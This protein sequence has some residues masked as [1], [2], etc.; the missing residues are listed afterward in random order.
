LRQRGFGVS[1]KLKVALLPL[2]SALL[3][4]IY[5]GMDKYYLSEV[6]SDPYAYSFLSMWLGLICTAIVLVVMRIPAKKSHLLGAYIDPNFRGFII[7]RGK[8][9]LWLIIAGV[10]AALQTITY[11]YLVGTSSPS[12]LLPFMQMVIVYLIISESVSYKETPTALEMQSV[13]MILVGIFLMATT[14]LTINWITIL[15]VLGP[16]NISTMVFTIALRQAKRMIYRG[17]K[18]DSLNL[19]FWSLLFLTLILSLLVIPFITPTFH[20]AL[21][22]VDWN[23]ILFILI[24][25][26]IST[27]AFVTYIRALGITKMST[28]TAII[29]VTVVLGIPITFIGDFFFPGA[30]GPTAFTPLFWL[31]KAM[32]AFLIIVGIVTIAISHVKA[33]LLIYLSDSAEPILNELARIKGITHISAVSGDRV[34][35]ATLN[36]RSLGSAYRT[37]I[38]DIEQIAGIKQVVTL[39]TLKE[40]EKL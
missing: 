20:A 25:V 38:T 37:I 29:S 3:T 16:Y 6:A 18:N 28:V 36:I 13:I 9:L 1:R 35:I 40:W 34:L 30:F 21:A 19:R 39:P 24:D 8:L 11:F 27:F 31:F 15:L 26:L 33:Y 2:I 10:S 5:V 4:A 22:I 32:G 12:L 17:R 23:I 7:P 14:D